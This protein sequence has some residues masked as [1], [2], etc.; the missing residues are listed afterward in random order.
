MIVDSLIINEWI[1]ENQY[2]FKDLPKIMHHYYM[3]VVS[4]KFQKDSVYWMRLTKKFKYG[5]F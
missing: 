2:T 5:N 1:R 4:F 3:N